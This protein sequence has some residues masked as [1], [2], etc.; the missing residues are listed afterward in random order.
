MNEQRFC[1][2]RDSLEDKP[3]NDCTANL[4]RELLA[5]VVR[6]KKKAKEHKCATQD[7]ICLAMLLENR[8]HDTAPYGEL[9][10]ICKDLMKSL[11]P[12]AGSP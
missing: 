12:P 11:L 5:E 7:Q 6:L 3:D 2:L 1:L 10:V 8:I 4:A 9:R